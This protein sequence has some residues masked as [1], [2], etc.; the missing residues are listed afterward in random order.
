M[1]V[2]DILGALP[3]NGATCKPPLKVLVIW[4]PPGCGSPD[5]MGRSPNCLLLNNNLSGDLQLYLIEVNLSEPQF[6][7]QCVLLPILYATYHSVMIT[8]YINILYEVKQ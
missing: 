7:A 2:G 6:A 5:R 1:S 3:H 4:G 8:N